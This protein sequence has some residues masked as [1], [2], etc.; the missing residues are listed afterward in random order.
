[1]DVAERG[2]VVVRYRDGYRAGAHTETGAHDVATWLRIY[3]GHAHAH[4][5][6]I[7]RARPGEA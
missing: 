6:R 1:M 7:A 3:A 5:A 4:A 2:Q